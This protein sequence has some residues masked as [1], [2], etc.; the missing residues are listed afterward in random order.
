VGFRLT[1][2]A[3]EARLGTVRDTLDRLD[4][5]AY[6]GVE[7]FDGVTDGV[8]ADVRV[9]FDSTYRNRPTAVREVEAV[10]TVLHDRIRGAVAGHL[11]SIRDQFWEYSK[12][13]LSTLT[14]IDVRRAECSVCG[15]A[16]TVLTYRHRSVPSLGFHH[17]ECDRCIAVAWSTDP[18]AR[19]VLANGAEVPAY[20]GWPSEFVRTVV[21]KTD[22]PVAGWLGFAANGGG[23]QG[24]AAVEPTEVRVE[25]GAVRPVR[26]STGMVAGTALGGLQSGWAFGFVGGHYLACQVAVEVRAEA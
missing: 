17:E 2:P 26:L 20:R 1:Q 12:P 16:G 22:R 14:E 5:L 9:A 13:Y 24:F 10:E 6:L 7:S 8:R 21:N 23:V 25:A 15:G 18:E 11:A 3:L 4:T 19:V